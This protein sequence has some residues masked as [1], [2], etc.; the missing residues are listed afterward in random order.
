MHFV[1]P[2]TIWSPSI[3]KCVASTTMT[4]MLMDL[5]KCWAQTSAWTNTFKHTGKWMKNWRTLAAFDDILSVHKAKQHLGSNDCT[6]QTEEYVSVKVV[7]WIIGVCM[8]VSPS[9]KGLH[10]TAPVIYNHEASREKEEPWWQ[11]SL[12]NIADRSL[13]GVAWPNLTYNFLK[14]Q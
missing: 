14:T 12:I 9:G 7:R 13:R 1:V 8:Y 10:N 4:P 3:S 2:S 11:N 6:H 5:C